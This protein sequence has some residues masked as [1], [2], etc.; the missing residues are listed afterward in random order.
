V[1]ASEGAGSLAAARS[2][3]AA[4]QREVLDDL[5]AGRT[6]DGFDPAGAR[7]TSRVLLA[8]RSSA[9]AYVAPELRLLPRWRERFHAWA[10]EHPQDGCAHDD[11]AAFAESLGDEPWVG[12]HEVYAGRRTLWS[13]RLAGQRV[14]AVGLGGSV[15]RLGPRPVG[16]T[17]TGTPS[18]EGGTPWS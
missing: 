3:L 5:L 10:A 12:L 11:V 14:I 2:R 13:G 6:P 16:R 1:T 8:K 9:A 15:W 7:L 4:R 18:T 17:P